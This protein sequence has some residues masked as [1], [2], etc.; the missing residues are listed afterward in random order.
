[1]ANPAALLHAQ[2]SEWNE[3]AS[4]TNAQNVRTPD[5]DGWE[6]QR[7]AAGYLLEIESL[8]SRLTAIGPTV[9]VSV[10]R[11]YLP[12]W[13]RAVFVFP[14]GWSEGGSG[15][16]EQTGLDQLAGLSTLFSLVVERADQTKF[17]EIRD[18]LNALEELIAA[19]SASVALKAHL[20]NVMN[21]LRWCID[22]Y[23]IVSDFEVERATEQLIATVARAAVATQNDANQGGGWTTWLNGFVWPFASGA[24]A[25]VVGELAMAGIQAIGS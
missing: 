7:R 2:L 15:A 3:P 19:S 14:K 13:S 16:I 12:L 25:T 8:L 24:T 22:N 18:S 9:D 21:H 5:E 4:N 11:R 23:D 20:R 17:D 1:M 10:Y 6:V